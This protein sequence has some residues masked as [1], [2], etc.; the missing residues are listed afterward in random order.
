M[1]EAHPLAAPNPRPSRISPAVKV[2]YTLFVAVLAA[3][4]ARLLGPP[5][6]L[7]VCNIALFLTVA[8]IWLENRF[9]ASMQL[10]AVFLVSLAWQ[11]DLLTRLT[12]GRFLTSMT[13][14]MFLD[15]VSPVIRG[16]SLYHVVFPYFLWWLVRRL[17]YDGRA[18][19]A[20]TAVTWV[21][22]PVGYY[23]TDPAR[24]LNAVFGTG[25][26]Q[27]TWM[28]PELYLALLMLFY[29]ACVYLPSHLLFRWVFRDRPESR[30]AN[31]A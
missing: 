2:A 7:W 16:L 21:V 25:S 29:P 14:Y 26:T 8:A 20:Q 5:N 13:H 9:L 19:L 15:T 10:V 12:T 18:W 22:L 17:G 24:N 1:G 6:F 28:P 31:A 3:F 30:V 27:Q 23:F 4:Y 11:A